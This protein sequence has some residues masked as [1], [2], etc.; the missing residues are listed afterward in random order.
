[1]SETTVTIKGKKTLKVSDTSEESK[2]VLSEG[3][4]FQPLTE[5]DL[6]AAK[7]KK[8]AQKRKET[9]AKKREEKERNKTT[10]EKEEEDS[11]D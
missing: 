2:T 6:K 7:I 3:L 1:M 11:L 5:E 8:A 4:E 9:W 10:E